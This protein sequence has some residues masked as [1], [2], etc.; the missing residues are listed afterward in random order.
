MGYSPRYQIYY[1]T[2]VPGSF[3]DSPID[4]RWSETDNIETAKSILLSL[5]KDGHEEAYIFDTHSS[6]EHET[7][8]PRSVH[9]EGP[10]RRE[11][12][13]MID[14]SG[15]FH[16]MKGIDQIEGE[17]LL[18]WCS[19]FLSAVLLDD[20]EEFQKALIILHEKMR[21]VR[22][23]ETEKPLSFCPWCSKGLK[24]NYPNPQKTETAAEHGK[25]GGR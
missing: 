24:W 25:E 15:G 7:L 3:G 2:V 14:N 13:S 1:S 11:E 16:I 8:E 6:L 19:N 5:K 9:P 22:D 21:R 18:S 17:T 4:A 23:A 20:P 10:T 12:V